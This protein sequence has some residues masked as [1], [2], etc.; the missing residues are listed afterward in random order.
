MGGNN[1]KASNFQTDIVKEFNSLVATN[2]QTNHMNSTADATLTM[3]GCTIECDPTLIGGIAC[4]LNNEAVASVNVKSLQ[5]AITSGDFTTNLQSEMDSVIDQSSEGFITEVGSQTDAIV[6]KK[7]YSEMVTS[8]VQNTI[9]SC[10]GGADATANMNLIDCSIRNYN[11]NN[12]AIAVATSECTQTALSENTTYNEIVS[13]MTA[14]TTQTKK[15]LDMFGWIGIIVGGVIGLV[16]F[17]I[18]IKVLAGGKKSNPQVIQQGAP[19][20][21]QANF[22]AT[23]N[24]VMAQI[25]NAKKPNP[26]GRM[27]AGGG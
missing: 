14:D 5:D 11:I 3:D 8:V 18:L 9:Q 1:T 12:T 13:K 21:A 15:G 24:S 26:K 6:S 7:A 16:I 17:V 4:E 20:A 22:A 23:A 19:P 2:I 27:P 25:A 10:F